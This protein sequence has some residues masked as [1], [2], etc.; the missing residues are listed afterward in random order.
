MS[1]LIKAEDLS[2]TYPASGER[3]ALPVFEDL[4]L[5]IDEGSFTAVIGPNG[6]GKSTLAKH[7]NAVLLPTGGKVWVA[8]LDTADEEKLLEIRREIGMVFQ[9]PDNQIVA[10][11]VEEDVA[12]APENLGVPSPEIRQRVDEALKIVGMYEYREHAPHLLSGG[13]KQRIAIAGVLAMRPRCIVLDEPTAMLDPR[14]RE[15]VISTI[16][17]L[18]REQGITVI[19]ITHHMREAVGADR[20]IVMHKGGILTDGTPREVFSQVELLRRAGL[21]VPQTTDLLFS[22]R[23]AGWDLPLDALTPEECAEA[24]AAAMKSNN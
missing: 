16:T 9:N 8:G 3:L 1:N 18:N 15:E 5:E 14:G 2:F 4:N 20:V 13:Q 21:D 23:N 11:V 17:R 7:F 24:I 22:L 19:L 12:F 6:C 10:N